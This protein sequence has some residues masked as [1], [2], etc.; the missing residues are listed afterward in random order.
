MSCSLEDAAISNM[1]HSSQEFVAENFGTSSDKVM[2]FDEVPVKSAVSATSSPSEGHIIGLGL[3][4]AVEGV[5]QSS[6]SITRLDSILAQQDALALAE[7]RKDIINYTDPLPGMVFNCAFL[8]VFSSSI[9]QLPQIF[10]L[11]RNTLFLLSKHCLAENLL[12]DQG[13]DCRILLRATMN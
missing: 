5:L 12:S 4:S 1:A 7:M 3:G 2:V 9:S 13:N 10:N 8:D 6:A 11:L